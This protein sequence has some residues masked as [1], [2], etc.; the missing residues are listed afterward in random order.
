[1]D[2]VA[3]ASLSVPIFHF[4]E[5]R[6]RVGAARAARDE[7]GERLEQLRGELAHQEADA[8]A[9]L[10]Q[11][12]RQISISEESLRIGRENL[13]ISTYAYNEGQ[14]TLLEVLQAQLSWIQLY[15]NS[16]H[17]DFNYRVAVSDYRR[18]TA[19]EQ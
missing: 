10:G 4:R 2:G 13:E 8:W 1:M 9:A 3:F 17:A 18:V 14:S 11:S 19:Q 5:R 6:S 12:R 16:I 15:T 7:A